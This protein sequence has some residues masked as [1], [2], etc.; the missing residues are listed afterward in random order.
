MARNHSLW[1][2]GSRR[3]RVK[4]CEFESLD[5]AYPATLAGA[6]A[7]GFHIFKHHDVDYKV[8]LFATIFAHLPAAANRTLLTDLDRDV[9]EQKV[10]AK[11]EWDSVQLYPDWTP[12]EVRAFRQTIGD[13]KILKVMSAQ[14][15]ENVVDDRAFLDRYKD[16]AD[17]ILLDSFRAGGTGK[18]ADLDHCRDVVALSPLP[19]FLA[20]G[21]TVDNVGAAIEH[22]KPF[23]VDVETG[24][25][26][27]IPGGPLIKNLDKC[28]RFLNAVRVNDVKNGRV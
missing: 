25:S 1:N 7:L 24:V 15:T 4:L 17:A 28:T 21:L 8:Q 9:L 16:V 19:V 5:A 27:R 14:S 12:A 23:G 20:G 11:L 18:L 6:D 10:M 22:V 3:T 26:D 13:V 2:A